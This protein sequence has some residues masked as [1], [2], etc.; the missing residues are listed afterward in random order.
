MAV[1]T[2][3]V[4]Y[5]DE[6]GDVTEIEISKDTMDLVL[7]SARMLSGKAT[8]LDNLVDLVT[9]LTD[10]EVMQAM[11]FHHAVEMLKAKSAMRDIL[12]DMF[13]LK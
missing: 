8:S 5:M 12:I 3:T 7:S 1:K 2:V 11:I 6:Q 13:G 4:N 10:N 9:E